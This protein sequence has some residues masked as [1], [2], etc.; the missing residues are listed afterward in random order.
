MVT[1]WRQRTAGSAGTRSCNGL[2]PPPSPSSSS[3]GYLGA[4]PFDPGAAS[5]KC[6]GAKQEGWRLLNGSMVATPGGG[7]LALGHESRGRRGTL[8]ILSCDSADP[9][10]RFQYDAAISYETKAGKASTARLLSLYD[11]QCEIVSR[12]WR[13]FSRACPPRRSSR[14]H[15]S[16]HAARRRT[17][18]TFPHAPRACASDQ[19]GRSLQRLP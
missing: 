2:M 10:Q 9:R 5:G 15:N 6:G 17:R 3:G 4:L 12:Q 14:P 11:R 1:E 7:C 8:R 18:A 13:P 16:G 19:P